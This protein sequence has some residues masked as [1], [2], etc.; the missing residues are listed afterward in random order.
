MQKKTTINCIEDSG[1]CETRISLQCMCETAIVIFTQTNNII[2]D[3][4]YSSLFLFRLN[5]K[6]ALYLMTFFENSF[7]FSLSRL[8]EQLELDCGGDVPAVVFQIL[9]PHAALD[10]DDHADFKNTKN[11]IFRKINK[12]FGALT[13]WS[14]ELDGHQWT[15]ITLGAQERVVETRESLFGQVFD[16]ADVLLVV[17][18][19]TFTRQPHRVQLKNSNHFKFISTSM[20]NFMIFSLN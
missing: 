12:N 5:N 20:K 15:Q 6:H 4:I 16:L 3:S 14:D 10:L 11:L 2:R 7:F 1:K 18:Q 13:C 8:D 19:L 9:G 17:G